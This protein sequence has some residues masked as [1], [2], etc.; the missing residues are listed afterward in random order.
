MFTLSSGAIFILVSYSLKGW[1]GS[2]FLT[3]FEKQGKLFK[4][5]IHAGADPQ[6]I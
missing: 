1:D 3:L 2:S 5:K 6:E 4:K